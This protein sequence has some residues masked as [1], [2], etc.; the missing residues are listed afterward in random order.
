MQELNCNSL[1]GKP[2]LCYDDETMKLSRSALAFFIAQGRRGGQ[3]RALN[4]TPARRKEIAV[5]ARQAQLT[6]KRIAA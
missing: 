3:A 6:A 2:R 1:A 5:K 4:L